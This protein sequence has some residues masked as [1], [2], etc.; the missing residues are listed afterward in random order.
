MADD[1]GHAAIARRLRDALESPPAAE[2]DDDGED[3]GGPLDVL[4]T[5]GGVSMGEK[6]IVERALDFGHYQ[7]RP[8][9]GE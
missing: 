3:A 5:T 9:S 1:A 8:M 7:V 6:D 2:D 4:V